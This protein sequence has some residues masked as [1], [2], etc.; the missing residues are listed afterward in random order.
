[1]I[2]NQESN[3]SLVQKIKRPFLERWVTSKG[4]SMFLGLG[5]FLVLAI[6]IGAL[7]FQRY[8][9]ARKDQDADTLLL[10]NDIKAKL[11]QA[12]TYSLSATKTL[13]LFV[14]QDGT[15]KEFDSIAPQLVGRGNYIDAVQI[16]PN[17]IIKYV[18]PLKG[19]DSVIN[20]NILNDPAQVK[21]AE[22]AIEKKELFFA[23]PFKLRQGGMGVVGRLPIFRKGKFWGFS[24][25]VIQMP[26]LLRAAGISTSRNDYDFQLAKIN[27]DTKQEEFFIPHKH[28]IFRGHSVTV[29]VPNGEWRISV[30]PVERYRDFADIVLL[31][32]LGFLFAMLGAIVVYNVARRP[33]KLNELVKERTSQLKESEENYKILFQKNPL[34]LWIYDIETFRFLEV[35]DAA[36]NLYGY[37]KREFLEMTVLSIRSEQ[38]AAKFIDDNANGKSGLREAGIW[39][40]IKKN[41][42]QIQVLVFSQNIFYNGVNGKLVLLMDVSEKIKVENELV[43]S[44]EKYRSLIEQSSDGMIFYSFDGT[45][46][47]FNK[48]AHVQTGYTREEFEKLNLKDIFLETENNLT[49]TN[50][51]SGKHTLLHRKLKRKD[52]TIFTVELNARMIPDGKIFAIIKDITQQENAKIALQESEEKF[53]K[54][55]HTNVLGFAIHDNQRK[56]VDMN[57]AYGNLLE[58]TRE[59][60][61][62]RSSDQAGILSRVPPD[63]LEGVRKDIEQI[64]KKQGQLRDYE[65]EIQMKNGE[66]AFLLISVEALELHNTPHWLTSA[67]NITSKKRSDR[68]IKESEIKY[69]S[70]IEQASDG[71]VITDLAGVIQEANQSLCNIGG[72]TLSELIGTNIEDV[73][74]IRDIQKDPHS[75]NE[76]LKGKSLLYERK[77]L[78]KDG[79]FLDV[80]VNAK[81]AS[82]N[83]VIA[84]FRDIS[85]R[86]KASAELK[87]SNERFE[88][89][90]QATND[91]VWDHD[92]VKNETWGN[93]KLRELNGF[94]SVDERIDFELL[95]SRIHS[96]EQKG[97]E[98]RM[99][100][101][102]KNGITYLTEEF[103]FQVANGEFR[104]FYNRV[105]IK[106]DANGQPLRILG[107]MQDITDREL[108]KKQIIKEKELSDSIINS[109]PGVFYLYNQQGKFRRWNK[110]FENVTGYNA[111]EILNLNPLDF[112]DHKDKAM[113]ASKISNVFT[114]GEDAV[115]ADLL[116]KNKQKIPFYFTGRAI[117]YEG[118]QC[119][120]GVGLDFS[121]NEKAKRQV[122]ESELKYKEL[123]EQASDGIFISNGEG[124]Y[125]DVNTR[126]C[127]MLGYSKE[128]LLNMSGADILYSPE[129][130]NGLPNR[131]EELRTGKSYITETIL[132]RK[133]G[134]TLEV[135]SNAKM[136]PDG[137]FIGIVRD[138]SDRKK[139]DKAVRESEERYRA[140][141]EN[142]PEAL[143]VF[144]A[145]S[146]KFV[147]VSE[148]A[149]KLFKY[150]REEL[151]TMSPADVSP[152]LQANGKLSSEAANEFIKEAIEGEKPTFEWIHMDKN[153]MPIEAEVWLVRLPSEKE[154]LIRGS[155]IDISARKKAELEIKSNSELLRDLYSDL[156]N[157]REEERKH[158][159]REIHDE[160]GQQL[161]GLKMDLFW[162]NRR[163]KT[164]DQLISEKLT[165]T[166]NLI[167]ATIKAVRKI[168]TELR[169]SILD[170]LGL[171]A[172]LEWQGEEFEKR[173]DIKVKFDNRLEEELV[174]PNISTAMFRIYQEVLTNVARHSKAKHV[175]TFSYVD[176]NN[177]FLKVIDDGVGFDI[178]GISNKKTLG[179]KGIQERTNLIGGACEIKSTP[180]EGTSV[181]ISVPL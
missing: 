174:Q 120:M 24:A 16:I 97:I 155:I 62:G 169:P 13:A 57:E 71:I 122:Y 139:A 146:Q 59:Q 141:V 178:S 147:N 161:T 130:I 166:L 125:I 104:N 60:L 180:G 69:R 158:I 101:A 128:E 157:I 131:Y 50:I 160:L 144:D 181:I 95:L 14:Q 133:D 109:L 103:P 21:E 173:F 117:E 110:N 22:K 134:S 38:E 96:S 70:L 55:F 43:K 72:Y 80:E 106:Y 143:V 47:S 81:M 148:S 113:I 45:I 34:P 140:L 65:I 145:K 7:I 136:L 30:V 41:K 171:V 74:P 28:D 5:A 135:E 78:K 17:G 6:L 105:Y 127:R 170:D 129:N 37:S 85:Q 107:A 115:E 86:I 90:S 52:G 151:L 35:N 48:S 91:A 119:L 15:V 26:T 142:A 77:L 12:L 94:Q 150:S 75:I 163:L 132:K 29:D 123:I 177:L 3:N 54:A 10:A 167:D 32:I 154:V 68:M 20:Y 8:K 165:A 40:H 56:L 25:V 121:E 176:N 88:L 53:S 116:L 39:S 100:D 175:K 126:A 159:A 58:S 153:G 156:Q 102:L 64:L 19:N 31:S 99:S 112:Y 61:I 164:D 42:E 51:R 27:P 152:Q 108:I 46:H 168:A 33:R 98:Q 87:K 44:E 162:I 2:N 23:G 82:S 11:Q 4:R 111:D 18:Y 83:T 76:L 114:N 172:A 138:L 9:L 89:I 92:F 84:F 93:Q 66:I 63:K 1:M 149:I 36:I 179:L 124:R 137:R 67:I 79:T 118:E 73:L 49:E